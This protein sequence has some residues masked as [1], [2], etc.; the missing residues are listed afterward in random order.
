MPKPEQCSHCTKPATIH[1]TQILNNEIKKVDLCDE[2][3]YKE[4]V[5][6][7]EGFSLAEFLLKPGTLLHAHGESVRCEQCGFTPLDFKKQGR[8]GCPVCYETFKGILKPML[9]NMHKDIVHRGKIPDRALARVSIKRKLSAL[10]ESLQEAVRNE[11]YEDAASLRDEIQLLRS[12]LS[13]TAP[14]R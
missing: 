7:P 14:P 8:F 9:A 4:G 5:T 3:P 13:E 1:L 6:D 11:H 12:S 10:E 2:C